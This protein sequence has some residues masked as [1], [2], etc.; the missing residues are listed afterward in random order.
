[1]RQF[2][3]VLKQILQIIPRYEFEKL[4][5]RYKADRYVKY[6]TAYQ[7]FVATLFG[8]IRKKDSLRDVVFALMQHHSKWAHLGIKNIARSTMA[9]ANSRVDY[10]I[11]EGLFYEMLGKCYHLTTNQ[12]FKFQNPLYALDASVIDLCLSV[13]NWAKF[14]K[15]KGGLKLHS[16]LNLKSQIPTFLVVTDAK[17]SDARIPQDY[18]LP[19]SPD[20]IITFD[21]AYIDFG[22]FSAYTQN[23]V[24]FVTRA[25]KNM[26]YRITGQ[27]PLPKHKHGLLFDKIIE[28]SNPTQ[29]RNYPHKLRLVGFK[30][31]VTGKC[32]EFL[33]NNFKLAASTIANIYKARWD[34]EL[35]FKWIK[36]N[37]KI[38]TFLGTSKNAVLSQI[39]IAMI[40]LLIL[41]YIKHQTKYAFSSLNLARIIQETLL[42]VD[43]LSISSLSGSPIS[44]KSGQIPSNFSFSK[45]SKSFPGH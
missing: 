19:L 28:L 40:Y 41:A 38:Q 3:T 22:V 37:L 18:L 23:G 35:F 39:W 10:R 25:K 24:W 30:D 2:S 20:S 26:A 12:R 11:Y 1:V 13:F 32:Y 27:L 44:T 33:S 29:R 9:D 15:T 34:I 45:I 21:R 16:L 4:I 14:R 5:R 17:V 43:L 7:L 36:Q 6:F 42:N 31:P 8:Q